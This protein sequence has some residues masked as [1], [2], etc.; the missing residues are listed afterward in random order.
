MRP[1]VPTPFT[2]SLEGA[3]NLFVNC[4]QYLAA[5]PAF[6]RSTAAVFLEARGYTPVRTRCP[7]LQEEGSVKKDPGV[8][9]Q[10]SGSE[11]GAGEN[12]AD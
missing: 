12:R 6:H 4:P 7:C 8:A 11:L 2:V 5:R 10:V 3:Q 1:V 9:G